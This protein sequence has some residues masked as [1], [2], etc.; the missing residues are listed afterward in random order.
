[1]LEWVPYGSKGFTDAIVRLLARKLE[2]H[3]GI[4]SGV[5]AAEEL[6]KVAELLPPANLEDSQNGA[7][8]LKDFLEVAKAEPR[9]LFQ[10]Y[11]VTSARPDERLTVEG[12]YVPSD[13][14]D[15]IGFLY[16]RGVQP[17]R[18]EDAEVGGTRYRYM[19]W[20]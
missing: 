20:D 15:L 18:E 5:I 11:V 7:P 1:M 2:L 13:R 16:K 8:T 9:T 14:A 10:V 4:Y 6:L 17:S 12:V 3:G 19:W